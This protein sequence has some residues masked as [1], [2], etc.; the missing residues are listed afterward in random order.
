MTRLLHYDHPIKPFLTSQAIMEKTGLKRQAI[1]IAREIEE[2]TKHDV[3]AF[4]NNLSESVGA[5]AKYIHMGL[6]S[7]DVLDTTLAVQMTRVLP[8]STRTEPL[9]CLR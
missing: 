2:K 9:G 3:V 1:G 5:N 6:T 4:V 7:N 8:I